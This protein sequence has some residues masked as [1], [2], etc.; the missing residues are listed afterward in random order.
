MSCIAGLFQ[1]DGAAVER[2]LLE[3]MLA[4]MKPRAPHGDTIL[5]DGPVGLAQAFLR[6]G[7][8][9]A[10][11]SPRLTLDGKVFI[12]ADARIDGRAELLAKLRARGRQ[13]DDDAP[14][15]ELILHAYAAFGDSFVD[16]LIGDFAF[17][18]WDSDRKRLSCVR[19]PFGVRRLYHVRS[20]NLFGFASDIDALHTL[21][22]VS[23][24]LN[25]T[26]VVDFLL[27]GGCCDPADTIY[28]D[29]RSLPPATRQDWTATGCTTTT[30]WHVPDR[31]ETRYRREADYAERYVEL[32]TQ[33]VQDRL[34]SGPLSVQLS[35]GMDSTSIA[36]IA[37]PWARSRAHP[38]TAFHA[39]YQRGGGGGEELAL[40]ELV[41]RHLGIPLV[42][43]DLA[44]YKLF[45]DAQHPSLR[46]AFPVSSARLPMH[47]D[48]MRQIAGGG[49]AVLLSGYGADALFSP[50]PDYVI[51]LL[52]RGR[53]FS[54]WRDLRHHVRHTGSLSGTGMKGLLRW[55]REAPTW[56]PAMPT[57]IAQDVAKSTHAEERWTYW[58]DRYQNSS[59]A[60]EQLA[61]PWL[62][63][64]FEGNECLPGPVVMRYPFLDVR[65]VSYLLSLPSFILTDKRIARLGMRK[66][67]PAV[68][69]SRPKAA[70]TANQTWET[71]T[72]GNNGARI[73]GPG[74][75][76]PLWIAEHAFQ[77]AWRNYAQQETTSRWSSDLIVLPVA[78]A[79]WL[80]NRSFE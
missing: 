70:I 57:W 28:Q 65:L 14:H 39:T 46:T 8:S 37:A 18:L 41:A 43:Q 69:T 73:L 25:E 52:R 10:E 50:A 48:M 32:L 59:S 4:P 13:L 80:R 2:G 72:I 38:V 20:G 49:G 44:D 79:H 66:Y 19:D 30:Y 47:R 60:R 53:F 23:S 16:H 35:G 71:V 67:L 27:F 11:A 78:L 62:H 45:A 9:G 7:S 77:E 75:N 33:A 12:V 31:T 17:A 40:A 58:L 56:Q 24:R 42:V 3:R 61:L 54:L 26:A 6:T 55:R 76:Q 34:P 51:Q 68:I 36:A 22:A 21:A 29:I 1:L 64:Q 5:V 15:A 63:R 74:I